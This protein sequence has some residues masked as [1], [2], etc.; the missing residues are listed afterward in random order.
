M[1]KA[2]QNCQTQSRTKH[3]EK[4]TDL[5]RNKRRMGNARLA[6]QL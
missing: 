1:S 3:R 2:E 4:R 6:A 5:R